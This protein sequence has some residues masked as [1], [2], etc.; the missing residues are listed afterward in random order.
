MRLLSLRNK[1]GLH[2]WP[3][4][5]RVKDSFSKIHGSRAQSRVRGNV[6][7]IMVDFGNFPSTG[8]YECH[9]SEK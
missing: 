4:I 7:C 3:H 1:M 2:E 5:W 6:S 9:P 8:P